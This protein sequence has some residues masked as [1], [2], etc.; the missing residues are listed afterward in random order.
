MDSVVEQRQN[1]WSN[2]NDRIDP[3]LFEYPP[4][5]PATD[6]KQSMNFYHG[7]NAVNNEKLESL[8][9]MMDKQNLNTGKNYSHRK[10][11]FLHS[12]IH[13]LTHSLTHLTC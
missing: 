9:N 7:L 1:E 4:N 10:I 11:F 5:T 8:R 3:L 6:P 13:S 12:L 2:N